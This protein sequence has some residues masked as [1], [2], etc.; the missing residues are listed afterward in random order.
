M[1]IVGLWDCEILVFP[2]PS[3]Y[4]GNKNAV[5]VPRSARCFGIVV[6]KVPYEGANTPTLLK[7]GGHEATERCLRL[8]GCSRDAGEPPQHTKHVTTGFSH[9][10]IY[11]H[12]Y[13]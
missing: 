13:S 9:I 7:H 1:I 6:L 4:K 2:K 10:Y 12:I 5:E 11:I 3:R 8:S